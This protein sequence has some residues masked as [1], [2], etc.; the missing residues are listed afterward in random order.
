MLQYLLHNY[1]ACGTGFGGHLTET[2]L[3][4][5]KDASK[6]MLDGLITWDRCDTS[7]ASHA[8]QTCDVRH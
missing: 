3:Q 7:D 4:R 5:A 6:R 2:A 8:L 1:S